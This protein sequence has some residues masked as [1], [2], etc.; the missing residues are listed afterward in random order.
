MP[1]YRIFS[2]ATHYENMFAKVLLY[3]HYKNPIKY[4][5]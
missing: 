1:L 5:S 2:I 4:S 3:E